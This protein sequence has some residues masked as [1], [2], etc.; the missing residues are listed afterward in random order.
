MTVHSA[1]KHQFYWNEYSV[2]SGVWQQPTIGCVRREKQG[3][4]LIN[5]IN[6]RL[7]LS[8]MSTITLWCLHYLGS[9]VADAKAGGF[10]FYISNNENTGWTSFLH[11]LRKCFQ[12]RSGFATCEPP[13][14]QSIIVDMF[15]YG[16][17]Q[18]LILNHGKDGL[19]SWETNLHK[20]KWKWPPVFLWGLWF[21]C[22][23]WLWTSD[24][25]S[26]GGSE[27]VEMIIS[28]GCYDKMCINDSPGLSE[29]EE[30]F[31]EQRAKRRRKW[32]RLHVGS[33][34]GSLSVH[35]PVLY[36]WIILQRYLN[37]IGEIY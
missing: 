6:Y 18:S 30:L 4:S 20:F 8:M 28:S 26:S 13:R 21:L 1:R 12:L 27:R 2:T 29:V 15:P 34:R 9:F 33:T 11:L 23:A 22:L 7:E 19:C 16:V 10:P 14:Q 17:R 35:W 31:E 32:R 25:H 24:V 5:K 37:K 36:S 3:A